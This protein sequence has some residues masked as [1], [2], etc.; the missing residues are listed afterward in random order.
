[1][2]AI[3]GVAGNARTLAA[4]SDALRAQCEA[5][6]ALS[7]DDGARATLARV[8]GRLASSV[9]APLKAALDDSPE[10]TVPQPA[11]NLREI[12]HQLHLLADDATRLRVRAAGN[13]TLQEAAAALQDLSCQAVADDV[14]RLEAR[15]TELTALMSGLPAA[16]QSASNGPYLL[17][18]VTRMTDWLGVS[19]DPTPQVALCRCGASAD[20]VIVLDHHVSEETST[21]RLRILKYRGSLHG[22]NEYPFLIGERG[23][24]VQPITSLGLRHGV[25]SERVSTG[26]ERLDV[27][28]GGR[29]PYRGSSVLVSGTAGTGKSTLAAAF[30]DAACS[31]GER[32]I[33]FAFEES[34]DQIIRNMSSVGMHLERWVQQGLLVFQCVRPGQLGLE[35]HLLTLRN[36]VEDFDPSVVVLD[37]ISDL[38]S[39]GS[40]RGRS[41]TA[42]LTREVDFLKGRG[43]TALFTTLASDSQAEPGNQLVAS[44]I[45]TVLLAGR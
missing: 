6:A 21:R 25:S 42:M 38:V 31:R 8:A 43:V 12:A 3:T 29:G 11:G 17:T 39:V 40:D 32:A 2:S 15:R 44:L 37:P 19:L 22:T 7:A 14:E 34:Q 9:I 23:I 28:L 16:I 24:S 20:C 41:A 45:D 36:L 30:C 27:M 13:L 18:N 10:P 35:A 26:V 1:M 4:R 5:L 33:Y